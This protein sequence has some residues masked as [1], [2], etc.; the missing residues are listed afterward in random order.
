MTDI[1]IVQKTGELKEINVKNLQLSELYKK[2]GFRKP[3]GFILRHTWKANLNSI[4]IWVTVFAR[5]IGKTN[6]ENKYD[7]PPPV[8]T[9]LYFGNLALVA[10]TEAECNDS[11][12][13]DLTSK[14]WLTI[15]ENLFGGFE[16]LSATV[17]QDELEFDEL[18][19]VPNKYKT[20]N[21]YL[22]DGFVVDSGE[23]DGSCNQCSTSEDEYSDLELDGSELDLE[24]YEYHE[25][26]LKN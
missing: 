16:D 13:T 1:V 9:T 26:E 20:K 5:D 24:E 17:E 23:D 19:N 18:D 22:K 11:T 6:T 2:C 21:G 8:D 15:Y 12:L 4:S 10:H 25:D 3:D 14:E 7:L